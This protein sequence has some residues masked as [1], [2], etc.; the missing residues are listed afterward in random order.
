MLH[1]AWSNKRDYFIFMVREIQYIYILMMFAHD[2]CLIS[3]Q[4]IGIILLGLKKLLSRL[5]LL[6]ACAIMCE[7]K[8]I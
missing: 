2:P 4:L 3:A 7:D 1:G 8:P 5:Y 6:D